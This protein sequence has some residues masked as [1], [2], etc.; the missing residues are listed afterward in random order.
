ML[1]IEE[2]I[3][4]GQQ[5]SAAW[6]SEWSSA[7]RHYEGRCAP[8]DHIPDCYSP[9]RDGVSGEE[10]CCDNCCEEGPEWA[11]PSECEKVCKKSTKDRCW[12]CA[13]KLDPESCMRTC[14]SQLN[15][16]MNRLA[17]DED[18]FDCRYTEEDCE[19][20][21]KKIDQSKSGNFAKYDKVSAIQRWRDRVLLTSLTSFFANILGSRSSSPKLA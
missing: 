16:D 7:F 5:K 19:Q 8:M 17:L 12:T 1:S 14:A 21:E 4:K 18:G 11:D 3:I 2:V 15:E 10:N 6:A 9:L 20:W 13:Q